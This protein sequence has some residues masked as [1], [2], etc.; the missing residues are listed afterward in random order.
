MRQKKGFTL[1]EL[2]MI[3]VIIGILAVVAIPRYINL[4]AQARAAAELGVVGA[5]RSGIM[6]VFA[7]NNGSFPGTLDANA[8]GACTTCFSTVLEYP[9]NDS[10]WSKTGAVYT[11]PSAATYTYTSG[12]G[13]F[14]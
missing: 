2:I 4:Q 10:T 12:T 3:I 5:V 8:N 13:S 9:I 1:I 14:Q 6:T 7:E 11:G